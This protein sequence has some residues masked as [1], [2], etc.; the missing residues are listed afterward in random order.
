MRQAAE[1]AQ[2]APEPEHTGFGALVYGTANDFAAFPRRKST[3]VILGIGAGAAAI[4]YPF[5][6]ELNEELQEADGLR[7][8]L[9]P[10]KYLGYGWVQGGAA[11][12]LYVIGRYAMKPDAGTR[13]NKLSHLGFDLLRANLVTQ[14]FTYGIKV[15]GTTRQTDRRVLRIPVGPCVR[16]VRH[17]SSARTALRLPGQLADVCHCRLRLGQSPDRQPPLLE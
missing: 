8:A 14:A 15:R 7:K 1:A 16:H 12:G 13:T 17:R 3:W 6:D 2:V 9:K 5:D 11:V 4:A 10:G